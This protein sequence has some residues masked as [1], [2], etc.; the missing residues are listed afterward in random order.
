MRISILFLTVLALSC[1]REKTEVKTKLFSEVKPIDSGI[2]FSND[3]QSNADF[4]IL[5]YLYFYNG[6]GVAIGDINNDSLP[7][8]YFTANQKP[9]KLY[10]NLGGF[11]F[12]DITEEANVAG[13]GNWSTGVTMAD[14]NGDGLLDIY[15]C[16]VSGYKGARGHNELFINN[17]DLSFTESSKD[18]GLNFSG[19]ATQAVFFDYDRDSDLDVY[20]LNHSVHSVDS[21]GSAERREFKDARAGDLLL[22]SQVAQSV[23]KFKDV[24]ATSGIYNSKIGYGLGV[25]AADV[26]ND[27]WPDIYVS[28]D[29][30]ENDYLYINNKDG[31]FIESL[32]KMMGH[33][34]RYS[35]GNDI[36]DVNNDGW[37]DIFTTDMLPANSEILMKSGGEDKSEINEIKLSYGY[38]HQLARNTLQL[39]RGNDVFSDIALQAGLSATDWSWSPLLAD[40]DND[41]FKDLF[42]S[43]GIVK[44]PND[45]D[46]I[47][48]ISNL[49]DFRYTVNNKDSIDAEMIKRMPELEIPNEAFKNIDGITWQSVN[50]EWGLNQPSYSNGAAYADLDNDGDLDLIINNI[51]AVA[52]VYKNNT[53]SNGNNYLK[54][55]LMGN[56]YNVHSVGAKVVIKNEEGQIT[57]RIGASKGFQSSVS[58][59]LT[60]GLGA[61]KL[62]DTLEIYWPNGQYQLL[63]NIEVN[64]WLSIKEPTTSSPKNNALAKTYFARSVSPLE[65]KHEEN[66][67]NDFN[68]DYL[69]PYK[70]STGGP[71][72]SVGDVDENGLD[73]VFLGGAKG[74]LSSFFLQKGSY[75][76]RKELE[77]SQRF[78]DVA[79]LLLDV[80]RDNDLDLIVLSAGHEYPSGHP[81][82]QDRL[83]LNE[84]GNFILNNTFPEIREN[85]TCVAPYDF[86]DDGDLDIFIGY[87]G[88]FGAYGQNGGGVLLQNDGKGGFKDITNQIAPELA[89]IGMVKSATWIDFDNDGDSDLILAGHWMPITTFI[90]DSG[91]FSDQTIIANSS[92]FWN[93]L[94]AYDLD[95]DGDKD[96]LAGN[97][98]SNNKFSASPEYPLKIY[99]DDFDKNGTKESIIMH[100]IDGRYIPLFTKDELEKQ[101]VSIKRRYT[102]YQKFA[103]DVIGISSLVKQSA[104]T[105]E[106]SVE[107]LQSMIFFNDA[108][109]YTRVP[110]P[111][112]MQYSN[113]NSILLTDLNKDDWVDMITIGNNI[114][115]HIN[116]GRYDA[117]FGSTAFS[118]AGKSFNY[119]DNNTSG[120]SIV[121]QVSNFDTLTISKEKYLIFTLNNDSIQLYKMN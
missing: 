22:Q 112:Q 59:D 38:G 35:M 40:F 29:F 56:G 58:P 113:I 96:L 51:N 67:Y 118:V 7:D 28:N 108:N 4:N 60:I 100:H 68:V 18:Y 25:S 55:S 50:D 52:F 10:L 44:R 30:H 74:Q 117:D 70:L 41:G 106:K 111:T 69:R 46:Y 61:C 64:Q 86:D 94:Q 39:N 43:N 110:L 49:S 17:G 23:L 116:L 66:N 34:S 91:A 8:I 81:L 31:T 85:S 1:A 103:T 48:Y 42:I 53:E 36:A 104:E 6:A 107:E 82:L 47:Q 65:W 93:T 101:L 72:L 75:F 16:N 97:I 102:S 11:Q 120:L 114:N 119:I 19:F 45:L 37:M 24:T 87:E 105:I 109:Q 98:G 2:G 78:E 32:E 88:P 13:K 90:N 115:T 89:G 27:G 3:L 26:N 83:Y 92:G 95:Q 5:E 63:E 79:S 84:D 14:V 62:I 9:N 57:Y 15:V 73:D 71:A 54:L 99:V 121:G 80:D 77:S 76:E 12:K 33:S 21:Y 20:L